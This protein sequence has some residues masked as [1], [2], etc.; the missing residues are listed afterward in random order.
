MNYKVDRSKW[1]TGSVGEFA[2]GKGFT[3]MLNRYGFMC[4]IGQCELQNEVPLDELMK[5]NKPTQI[6]FWR[7]T[8]F[9]E[10]GNVSELGVKALKINDE[11]DSTLKEKEKRMRVL[12]QEWGHDIVFKGKAKIFEEDEL[13]ILIPKN[14][15]KKVKIR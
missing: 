12:F 10:K 9:V 13:L 4:I 7:Q 5:K 3:Q 1:R 11:I 15:N 8:P 14:K 6:Q 2:T